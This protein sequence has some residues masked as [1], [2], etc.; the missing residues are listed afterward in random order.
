MSAGNYVEA[1]IIFDMNG[2]PVLSSRFNGPPEATQIK[3]EPVTLH[4]AEI[5]R[6][7]Y[8]DFEKGSGDRAGLDFGDCCAYALARVKKRPFLY[9][10]DDFAYT[11]IDGVLE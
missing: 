4:H 11:G 7:A 2:D 9:K 1:A 3:V 6:Q 8:R 10:G 5:A